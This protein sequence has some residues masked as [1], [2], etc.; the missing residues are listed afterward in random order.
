[1][2]GEGSDGM[3][4]PAIASL[5]RKWTQESCFRVSAVVTDSACAN[6]APGKWLN[7]DRNFGQYSTITFQTPNCGN[8]PPPSDRYRATYTPRLYP[9]RDFRPGRS[10][11]NP[12]ASNPKRQ[13]SI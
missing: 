8:S 13:I 11:A 5:P 7:A 4:F 1:M 3:P 2:L 9:G 12:P 10:D 6:A